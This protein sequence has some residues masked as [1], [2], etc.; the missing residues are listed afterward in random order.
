[1]TVH[2]TMDTGRD[3]TGERP[4]ERRTTVSITRL[5]GIILTPKIS[6]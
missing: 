4:H 1:M 6:T 5:P 2:L 3:L